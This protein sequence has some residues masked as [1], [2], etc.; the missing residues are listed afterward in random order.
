MTDV[1]EHLTYL[2]YGF[3]KNSTGFVSVDKQLPRSAVNRNRLPSTP[4][5][6]RRQITLLSDGILSEKDFACGLPLRTANTIFPFTAVTT[7]MLI[8]DVVFDSSFLV[9]AAKNRVI[10]SVFND[11]G[12]KLGSRICPMLS[13]RAASCLS[14]PL[15]M[16]GTHHKNKRSDGED[17]IAFAVKQ[18]TGSEPEKVL[19]RCFCICFARQPTIPASSN[20][21]VASCII[22]LAI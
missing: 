1:P 9:Q 17:Q 14:P 4:K 13:H 12:K 10:V 11:R 7:S 6:N 20:T 22:S 21:C 16:R 3:E 8:Q 2:G 19:S 18:H 5:R 15:L